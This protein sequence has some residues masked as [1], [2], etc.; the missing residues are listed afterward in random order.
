MKVRRL[1]GT[2][3]L[4]MALVAG[5][6][7]AKAPDASARTTT[8][9]VTLLKGEKYVVSAFLGKITSVKSSKKSVMA[10]KKNSSLKATCTAKKAGKATVTVRM[11][12]GTVYRYKFT[13][14][15]LK[16]QIKLHSVN[17]TTGSV[18]TTSNIAL[19]I[20]NKSGVYIP[21]ATYKLRLYDQAGSELETKEHSV[22][23]LVPGAK[24]YK[25][26][27][28]YGN[29]VGNIKLIGKVK[30]TRYSDRKYYNYS[31][32]VKVTTSKSGSTI[33]VKMKN[34]T[35][36][37][38]NGEADVVFYNDNGEI[39]YIR[40]CSFY[41]KSKESTTTNVTLYSDIQNA[42]YKIFKRAYTY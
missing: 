42:K 39:I 28:Y 7:G 9:S 23:D 18:N 15:A 11:T 29:P 41:L 17:Y 5:I 8:K 20:V 33:Q 2:M 35:K 26:I 16:L 36:K 34:K 13:V 27:T 21:T 6:F 3:V 24:I 40:S 31:K 1:M 10:V 14:K 19:E 37:T 22:S 12:G 32:K 25:M 30:G 4:V 38:V